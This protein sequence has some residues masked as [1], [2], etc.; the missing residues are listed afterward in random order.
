M[1]WKNRMEKCFWECR[2]WGRTYYILPLELVSHLNRAYSVCVSHI[3]W[4]L[5]CV[6]QLLVVLFGCARFENRSPCESVT[7]FNAPGPHFVSIVTS[8]H[9]YFCPIQCLLRMLLAT[10]LKVEKCL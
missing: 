8:I 7:S 6:L 9:F 10:F 2:W 3:T 4:G 5:F 1:E